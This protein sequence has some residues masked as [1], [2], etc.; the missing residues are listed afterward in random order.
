MK[1]I[2]RMLA[3]AFA[4]MD[5]RMK[6]FTLL[7]L[8]TMVPGILLAQTTLTTSTSFTAAQSGR[9]YMDIGGVW[10]G[11]AEVTN[12]TGDTFTLAVANTGANTAYEVLATV[13]LPA[14]FQYVAGTASATSSCGPVAPVSASQVGLVLTFSLPAGYDLVAGC[15]LTITYGLRV[16]STMPS[17]GTYALTPDVDYSNTSNGTR[18]QTASVSGQNILVLQGATLLI[19]TPTQ[20]TKAVGQTA[21]FVVTLTNS[22]LGALYDVTINESAINPGGSLQVATM[23][24]TAP[25]TPASGSSPTLTLGYLAPGDSFVVNVAA[26][27]TGCANILNTVS[28]TDRTGFTA[29]ST[30]APV[31]LDLL[32]P[33]IA[34]TPSNVTLDYTTPVAVSFPV[35]N[36][37]LGEARSIVLDTNL[38]TL[39]VTVASVAAGW[40]YNSSNGTFTRTAGSPAG[41]IANGASSTLSFTLEPDSPNLCG[42]TAGGTVV[43]YSAYTNGCGDA[44]GTPTLTSSVT[45]PNNQPSITLGQSVSAQRLANGE[46]GSY[47]VTLSATNTSLINGTNLV[48]TETIPANLTGVIMTPSA[49]SAVRS[50]NTITWTVP[51]ASLGAAQTLIINFVAQADPC[52]TGLEYTASASTSATSTRGCPLSA[53]ASATYLLTNNP[54]ATVNQFFEVNPAASDGVFETGNASA[55]STREIAL[56]EGEFIPFDASYEFGGAYPGQW[57]GSTYVDDFAGVA[58]QTLVPGTAE[59]SVN[60]GAFQS[61]PGGSITGGSGN[62]SINLSFVAGVSFANSPNVAGFTIE[63]RYKTTITDAGLSGGNTR[64][65]LQRSTLTVNGG[66]GAGAC[67]VAGNEF[68]QGVYYSIAR[69]AGTIGV[70]FTYSGATP[71]QLS[72]CEEFNVTLTVGNATAEKIRNVLVTLN[73]AAAQY[74]YLTGGSQTVSYGGDFNS[75]NIT[76]AENGG[77]N[78]TFTYSGATLVNSGTITFKARLKATAPLSPSSLGATVAYDDV[79]TSTSAGTRE[80]SSSGS[81]S[82]FLVRSASISLTVTPDNVVVTGST[83]QWK[84]YVTNGGNG[85]AYNATLRNTLYNTLELNTGLTNAANVGY[86]V[87]VSGSSN[88]ILTWS[89][90]DIP[91]GTTRLITVVA[92][93]N[94]STGCTIPA[95]QN[96][97]VAEWGCGG[98]LNQTVTKVAPNYTFPSGQMLV[99][100]DTTNSVARLCDDGIIYIIVRNTGPTEIS[101]ITL[102]EILDPSTGLTYL[103]G[104]TEYSINSGGSW[105][106]GGEPSGTG[107][108][109]T[110]YTWTSTQVPNLAMLYPG[111]VGGPQEVRIRFAITAGA[112]FATANPSATA[113]ATGSIACG[114]AVNSPGTSTAIPTVKP[115]VSIAVTGRNITAN[116]GASF[117]E[118]VYGGVGDQIEWRMVISNTGNQTARNVRFRQVFSG[119][120]GTALLNGPGFTNAA[121][122]NNTYYNHTNVTPGNDLA[123]GATATYVVT[124]TLGANCVNAVTTGNVVWGCL[125]PN[126]VTDLTAP[127]N[128]SDTA[129]LNMVPS[130]TG[131]TQLTQAITPL[132]GGRAM[133][134]VTVTNVGGT[135]YTPV[136]TATIP[137]YAHHDTTGPVT[138]TTASS[139]ITAVSRTGGTDAAPVFTFTGAG[140]PHLLRFGETIAFTYYLKPTVFDPN[141]ATTFPDLAAAETT[142]G[143]L[144]PLNSTGGNLVA[145]LDYTSSCGNP[146]SSNNSVT[147]SVRPDLD[148][149]ALGPNNGNTV[150]TATITQNYTFTITN[151]GDAGS[152]ADRITLSLPAL[153]SGWTV[154]SV[155]LTTPGTGGSGGAATLVLGVYTFSP[156]QVGTLAQNQTTVITANLTYN[157]ATSSGPLT[158]KALVQGESVDYAGSSL[159]NYSLDQRAHR[160]LGVELIKALLS[161]SEADSSGTNVLIGE[162]LTYRLTARFRGAESDI[163]NILLRDQ[164]RRGARTGNDDDNFGFVR[165]GGGTPF[166]TTTGSHNT[167]VVTLTEATNSAGTSP[168]VVSGR[169]S[170]SVP[171]ITPA[172]SSGGAVFEVDLVARVMN[173]VGTNGNPDNASRA[174]RAALQFDYLGTTFHPNTA[175]SSTGTQM[176]TTGVQVAGLYQ[177]HTVT[178]QRPVL[179][180]TKQVRNVTTSGAFADSITG[181]ALD[182]VEY[183]LVVASTD[184]LAAAYDLVVKDTLNAKMN[185]DAA[186]LFADLNA[187][188]VYDAGTDVQPTAGITGGLGGTFT[189]TNTELTL[190]TAGETLL[191]LAPTKTV[192]LY[193]RATIALTANPSEV[194]NNA[195]QVDADTLP[196]TSGSQTAAIGVNGTISGAG[197]ITVTDIATVTVNAVSQ[198][199]VLTDT[200]VGGDTSTDVLIGEQ[201]EIT[202]T[203]TLPQGTVPNLVITITLPAG[204]QWLGNT[205]ATFGSSISP[206]NQPNVSTSPVAP[207]PD[208]ITTITLDYGTPNG[209][210]TV[211]TGTAAERSIVLKYYVQVSNIAANNNGDTRTI[212]ASYQFSGAPAN[213]NNIVLTLREPVLTSTKTVNPST[214]FDA[215]ATLTFTVTV[216]NTSTLASAYNLNLV[217]TLPAGLT[218]VAG[219]ATLVTGAGQTTGF[220]DGTG[221]TIVALTQPDV[222]SQVLTFGR[223]QTVPQDYNLQPSGKLVFT[224]Q[225]TVDDTVQMQAVLTNSVTTDATSLAGDPGP[226]LA[227]QPVIAA[228]GTSLGERTGPGLTAPNDLRVTATANAT[229]SGTYTLLKTK[230]NDTLPIDDLPAPP[231]PS[232]GFRVGDVVTYTVAITLPEGTTSAVNIRDTLPTGMALVDF[233]PV[234]PASG[235]P[236]TYTQP[237][238]GSTAPSAGAT[239]LMI[240]TLGTVV[241]TG[242]NNGANNTLTLVYRVR[243]KDNAVA[244]PPTP[245][246][247]TISNSAVLRYTDG[248]AVVQNTTPSPNGIANVTLRQPLLTIAKTL[249]SPGD[250]TLYTGETARFRLTITNTGTAPAYNPTIVDTLPAGLRGATPTLV[251]ATLGGVDIT[252]TITPLVY[253]SGNGQTTFVLTDTEYLL[254]VANAPNNTLVLT[255]D[256]TAASSPL[257]VNQSN[258]AT[259]TQYFS[260]PAAD[261]T[262]RRT[263]AAVGPVSQ[264][265]IIRP[266]INGYVYWDIVNNSTKDGSEDWTQGPTVYV[267]LVQGG[268]VLRSIAINPGSGFYNFTEVANGSYTVVVTNGAANP[269]PVVPA[270]WFFRSPPSGSLPITVA[271]ANLTNQNFGLFTGSTIQGNVFQDDGAGGG[272]ANDG[273]RNGAE[274]GLPNVSVALTNCSGTTYYSALTNGAGDFVVAVPTSITTGTQLCVTETNPGAYT[275]T[276][277]GAGDTGGSYAR[278]T[279]TVTFTFTSGINYTGLRFGDVPPSRLLTDGLQTIIPGATAF[280]SHQFIAGT[281]GSVTFTLSSVDTPDIPGWS[282]LLYLDSNGDAFINGGEPQVTA[283]IAVTAGQT[284]N[285]LVKDTSPPGALYGAQNKT[286]ITAVLTYALASPTITE[287]LSRNDLTTLGQSQIAGLKLIKATDKT[288]ALPGETITYTI[289]YTNVSSSIISNL[290]ISDQTPAFTTF[291]SAAVGMPLPPSLTGSSITQPGVGTTGAIQW[292]F[293]GDL[294]SAQSGTVSYT[295]TISN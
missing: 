226:N 122:S 130:V 85:P 124:E 171:T 165:G 197:T 63:I 199:Q 129:T 45:A 120:S 273:I 110:P 115:N 238:A 185:L 291:T 204:L 126:P 20:Q 146:Y 157:N 235:T 7:L 73:S 292:S 152:I 221:T 82:P 180:L 143:S 35:Q 15:T 242:D 234:S 10:N 268:A 46:A 137:A 286:I 11:T 131:G 258:S 218:Y 155:T 139:D 172:A 106:S 90:G 28:S 212:A 177:A 225:A 40:S 72:I 50:V 51:I 187:N 156:A 55:N 244:H 211:T 9:T 25:A 88:E 249:V 32:Q 290:I 246:T 84:I 117:T 48:V 277:G 229:P 294:Q 149:T 262:D 136:L 31:A 5:E 189:F 147:L 269:N 49:G 160:I 53:S 54:G 163:T 116:A 167:G 151:V 134:T 104:T 207:Q 200:S 105:A 145:T 103:P 65:L 42:G 119:S 278:G 263:Y 222:S 111:G 219:S 210:F 206:Q 170:L 181:Q 252:G 220:V 27:V 75:G 271:G 241:N 176:A 107:S 71:N 100:H 227:T 232:D 22:G 4:G 59:I 195:A 132:A 186:S 133:V 23:T 178:V 213:F 29:K 240:W 128:P 67:I 264:T 150:L 66:G 192:T 275:S 239:G 3:N 266:S 30:T 216:N 276:G 26:T 259:I 201:A 70:A 114:N 17:S 179:T 125:P 95:N 61:I 74:T 113:S 161:T 169:I 94:S 43:W 274:A 230:S 256:V 87:T 282:T 52:V 99:A 92:D 223:T 86:P 293:V 118:T 108:A 80:F 191:R 44:Y 175:N 260:K 224:I 173:I 89:L 203:I 205:N 56:G 236:F 281:A 164:L 47:T 19:K 289:T 159:G 254:P 166:V 237:V 83:I 141:T 102:R 2:C 33:L 153:G 140:A 188:G 127:G 261:A 58:Q 91:A 193:Y 245:T 62:L 280:Y 248:L 198:V 295:V 64:S 209:P 154:N 270:N 267:N 148:V 196:G 162:E 93:I 142:T 247:K 13:T 183:R 76:Y 182:T 18:D 144:D 97:I 287:T 81:T 138:L 78:P 109:G 38:N 288:T 6:A 158:L 251:S 243:I 123:Q 253:N 98:T 16:A 8:A 272:T 190:P 60:G 279:D 12:T 41:S 257:N 208:S 284:I 228:A 79:Q 215:G 184:N 77:I 202:Q 194:L 39:G 135:L 21:N 250:A 96:I 168:T 283:A 214:S 34:Y 174:N 37:G 57:N 68:R 231:P 24:Q 255:Y 217:D 14:H 69:A 112:A 101:A 233:D 36:T 121:F 285:L 265:I 1:S